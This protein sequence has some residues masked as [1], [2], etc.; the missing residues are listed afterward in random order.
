VHAFA[1]AAPG[2]YDVIL[3]DIRMPVLNGLEASAQIR[4]LEHSEAATIPI[5]A[6]TAN[7]SEND[8]EEYYAAGMNGYLAKPISMA[9]LYAVLVNYLPQK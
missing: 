3:M 8:I 4:A 2:T 6:M 1:Q 7:T 5:I 9:E